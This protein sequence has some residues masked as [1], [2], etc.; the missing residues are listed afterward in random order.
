MYA[1]TGEDE[2]NDVT[3]VLNF[4]GSL[5]LPSSIDLRKISSDGN[6]FNR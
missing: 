4:G 1:H 2:D 5:K 6:S 3:K